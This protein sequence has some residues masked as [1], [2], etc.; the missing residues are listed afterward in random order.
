[1]TPTQTTPA[2]ATHTFLSVGLRPFFFS[3]ALFAALAIP[4][5][6]LMLAQGWQLAGIYGSRGWHVHEML[7]GYFP[8]VLAGFILTAIPNWTGRPPL[9]GAALGAAL[10]VWL[11]G[12]LAF[13]LIPWHWLVVA[14]DMAFLLLLCAFVL[15][16]II[17]CRGWRHLPIA[18]L[19][20]LLALAN[21]LFHSQALVPELAGYAE[22]LAVA[23]IA[24]FISL[25]G[26][27]IIPAFTRNWLKQQGL[28]GRP[29]EFASYDKAV[30]ALSI[31]GL[32]Q[33][34]LW[35]GR[36]VTGAGLLLLGAAHLLRLAR[37]QFWR[38]FRE[39]LV[40][41]LH[42]GYLWLG[43]ALLLM[44]LA[45][46]APAIIAPSTALH[47]LTT[48]A[49]GTM[50]LAVMTRATRGHSG[51][52]L[53]ADRLSVGIYL[54]ITG[55]AVLRTGIGLWPFDYM[56]GIGLSAGLWSLAFVLF[57]VSYGPMLLRADLK[58]GA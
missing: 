26:G 9:L 58:N 55:A 21:G 4:L 13:A 28:A 56:T 15:R 20:A 19:I 3:A 51:R 40:T 34:L 54:C 46:L 29:A 35:P 5:W 11:A 48:G 14:L 32:L 37:W 8:A 30:I 45:I 25:I 41:V 16:E 43:A 52:P 12:R 7:L 50:T 53:T 10:A 47:A 2:S 57:L 23:V 17:A 49:V 24:L 18:L 36:A 33:W 1:M 44:G 22:R 39:P 27:R 6:S 42:L 31:A 38:T